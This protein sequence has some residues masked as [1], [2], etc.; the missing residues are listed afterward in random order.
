MKDKR[1]VWKVVGT[2]AGVLSGMATR[3]V[4]RA[5]WRRVKGGDPPTNPAAPGTSW[6]EALT[7]AA[8][9]GVALAVTRLVAQRGAAEA[10]KG[11]MGTYPPGLEEVSP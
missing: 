5:G 7:W 2:L 6:T 1:L 4:L 11:Q 10:W 3:G 9:S 8:A